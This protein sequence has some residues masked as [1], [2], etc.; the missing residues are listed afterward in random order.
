PAADFLQPCRARWICPLRICSA[1]PSTTRM[2]RDWYQDRCDPLD[3][4]V[5]S[6]PKPVCDGDRS[7]RYINQYRR[8]SPLSRGAENDRKLAV[9]FLLPTLFLTRLRPAGSSLRGGLYRRP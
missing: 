9:S 1:M 5:M 7:P 6:L 3:V 4:P 2:I 8:C